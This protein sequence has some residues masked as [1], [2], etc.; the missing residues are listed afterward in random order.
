MIWFDKSKWKQES[1]I[2]ERKHVLHKESD[3][4]KRSRENKVFRKIK[5]NE[6][7]FQLLIIVSV[8]CRFDQIEFI[9]NI[10][11]NVS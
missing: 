4:R 7:Y 1:K 5:K 9:K 3:P 10:R 11:L 2:K 6:F 8:I